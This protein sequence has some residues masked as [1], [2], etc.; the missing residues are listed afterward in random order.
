MANI[1][2]I[3]YIFLLFHEI[4]WLASEMS[5]LNMTNLENIGLILLETVQ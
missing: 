5:W 3:S 2:L 4:T 1:S